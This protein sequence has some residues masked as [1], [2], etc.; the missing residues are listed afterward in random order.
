MSMKTVTIEFTFHQLDILVLSLQSSAIVPGIEAVL[1]A[2]L[3]RMREEQE[4]EQLGA[5]G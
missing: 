1:V 5:A 4:R 3:K 2:E